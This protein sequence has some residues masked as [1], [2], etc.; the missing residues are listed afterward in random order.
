MS[1]R[2]A[3]LYSQLQPLTKKIMFLSMFVG[4]QNIQDDQL[5]VRAFGNVQ[6]SLCGLLHTKEIQ[7]QSY[8]RNLET[9]I[10]KDDQQPDQNALEIGRKLGRTYI[11]ML[12]DAF[13]KGMQREAK[14]V[15]EGRLKEANHLRHLDNVRSEKIE[16]PNM[17]IE[18]GPVAR[19]EGMSKRGLDPTRAHSFGILHNSPQVVRTARVPDLTNLDLA[20]SRRGRRSR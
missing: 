6:K 20:F 3:R 7:E 15:L 17:N 13:D 11:K 14:A 5:G 16:A 9:F 18:G 19:G 4:G 8:A 2:S 12:Q 1:S 10:L